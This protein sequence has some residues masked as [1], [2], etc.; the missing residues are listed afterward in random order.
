MGLFKKL[1]DFISPSQT[2]ASSARSSRNETLLS[3]TKTLP[4]SPSS[5][6]PI[7]GVRAKALAEKEWRHTLETGE[8]PVEQSDFSISHVAPTAYELERETMQEQQR[9]LALRRELAPYARE[10]QSLLEIPEKSWTLPQRVSLEE[11]ASLIDKK[12]ARESDW[13]LTQVRLTSLNLL[14]LLQPHDYALSFDQVDLR[15]NLRHWLS[16]QSTQVTEEDEKS[17][18][19]AR[20]AA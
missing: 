2:S 3:L 18:P 5:E 9:V 15:E 17:G 14:K 16:A 11:L 1:A 6:P 13:G 10:L 12:T 8:P 20:R 7:S 19:S 4:D